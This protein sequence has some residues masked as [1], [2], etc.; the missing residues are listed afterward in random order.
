MVEFKRDV[1][2]NRFKLIEINPKFWGSLGLAIAAGVDFP[3]LAFR[4]ACGLPIDPPS[5]YRSVK[6]QW[7][8]MDIAH[9]VAVRKPGLWFR[10]VVR[11]TPNDFRLADPIPNLALIANGALDVLRGRRRIVARGG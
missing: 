11:G 1:A 8:S 5:D 2:D 9:S 7:L 3:Y 6:Y 4:A 10:E